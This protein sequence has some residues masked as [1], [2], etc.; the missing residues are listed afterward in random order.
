MVSQIY[1]TNALRRTKSISS[2]EV[3]INAISIELGNIGTVE[4]SKLR[5]RFATFEH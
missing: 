5:N 4:R 3:W 2:N 1:I